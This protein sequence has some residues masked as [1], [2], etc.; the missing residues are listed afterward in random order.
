MAVKQNNK[1]MTQLLLNAGAD[2]SKQTVLGEKALDL[3]SL[4]GFTEVNL[5]TQNSVIIILLLII[6]M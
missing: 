5:H 4:N 3:A 1:K 6:I 2:C